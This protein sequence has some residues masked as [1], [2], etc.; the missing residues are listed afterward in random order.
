MPIIG[1]PRY[2]NHA[3]GKVAAGA[4]TAQIKKTCANA[5][6]I[7]VRNVICGPHTVMVAEYWLTGEA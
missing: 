3:H 7:G 2:V 1:S 4:A 6:A 5:L